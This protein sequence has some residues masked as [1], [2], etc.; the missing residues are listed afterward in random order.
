MQIKG[1]ILAVLFFTALSSGCG[2]GAPESVPAR[3]T[4]PT[5]NEIERVKNMPAGF[6]IIGAHGVVQVDENYVNLGLIAKGTVTIPAGGVPL[7]QAAQIVVAGSSPVLCIRPVSTYATIRRVQ[8][9]GGTYSY[10]L[11][12]GYANANGTGPTAETFNWY[13]F[14]RMALTTMSNTGVQVFNA[15]G[16]I[17]F[18]SNGNPMRVAAVGQIQN[19]SIATSPA[20]VSAASSGAYAACMTQGRIDS[21]VF[22]PGTGEETHIFIEAVKINA[23]GASTGYL[24]DGLIPAAVNVQSYQGGQILLVDVAGL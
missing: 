23:S 22:A 16:E 4:Q 10:T 14:D 20:V 15:T 7:N 17:T 21:A 24:M 8:K 2:G 3:P 12:G 11:Q 5:I 19:A 13:L 6:Q 1:T 9:S 18:N